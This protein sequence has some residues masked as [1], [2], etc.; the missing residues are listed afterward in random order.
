M[1]SPRRLVTGFA[2][3]VLLAGCGGG[4]AGDGAP[5][6]TCARAGDRCTFAPGKLGLCVESSVEGGTPRV[7]CQSQH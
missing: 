2:L 6:A 7:V 4:A 3:L 1:T 5:S